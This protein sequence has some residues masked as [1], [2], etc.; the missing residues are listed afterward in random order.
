M[1]KSN[2]ARAYQH[3]VFLRARAA[4]LRPIAAP[5][6]IEVTLHW[7]RGRKS[8]DL[9]KRVS[10]LLDALQGA[11]YDSDAQIVALHAHRLDGDPNPRVDILITT[12]CK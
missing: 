5:Q 1:H 9:D 3:E 10:I 2:E 6:P 11:A 8:G 12:S 4:G 7:F